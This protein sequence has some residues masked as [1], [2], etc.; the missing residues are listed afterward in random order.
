MG[1]KV[2]AIL[3]AGGRIK[4]RF[5]KEA[6]AEIKALIAFEGRT[7]L[8]RTLETLAATEAV[9][10]TVLVGPQEAIEHPAACKADAALPEAGSGPGN[11]FRGLEWLGHASS[12]GHADR[13]LIMTTDLPFL[14]VQAVTRL[15]NASPPEAEVSLPVIERPE[16][17]ARFPGSPRR[18]VPLR[19]GHWIIGC[20]ALLDPQAA[21]RSRAHIEH[22][23]SARKN[24]LALAWGLGAGFLARFAL[25]RLTV[26]DIEARC[27]QILACVGRAVR[28]VPPELGFDID[29]LCHY[30]YVAAQMQPAPNG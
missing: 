2:D 8:E 16:F 20:A 6:G 5:A 18:Y 13:V 15:L 27:E 10:H 30:R 9:R 11:I 29:R 7:V 21:T 4:G 23:F 17:E 22:A 14:T 3:P 25:R 1:D 26:A 12:S 19:D 28:H 24:Q